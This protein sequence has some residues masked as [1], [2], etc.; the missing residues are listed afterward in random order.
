MIEH[1][2]AVAALQLHADDN[3]QGLGRDRFI[4]RLAYHYDQVNYIHPFREGNGRTPAG[5]LEPGGVRCRVAAGLDPGAGGRQR[6]GLPGGAHRRG[7]GV[8]VVEMFDQIVTPGRRRR[9]H[10]WRAA[11]RA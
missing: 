6:P 2:A 11:E 9:T 10:S 7:P 1:G 3:L 8:P 4:E 5:V